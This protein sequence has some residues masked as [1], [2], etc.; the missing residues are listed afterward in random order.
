MSEEE[1]R[2]IEHLNSFLNIPTYVWIKESELLMVNVKIALNLIQKQQKVLEEYERIFD[3][4][5]ERK[6]RK[7]Y[8]EERR[9]E[10]PN[11]LY[12][13]TDEIY[14][15]YYEEKEKNNNLIKQLQEQNTEIQDISRQL[16]Q[17]KEKNKVLEAKRIWNKGRI[18]GLKKELEQEKEKNK[19]LEEKLKI[20]KQLYNDACVCITTECV[21][22]DKIKEKIEELEKEQKEYKN[23][24]EWEIQDDIVAQINIL[25]DLLEEK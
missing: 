25:K 2:A 4:F 6:Y 15:K 5:N 21:E 19:E 13:D 17:E 8:L 22:K 3:V 23:S 24:Q 12:P 18:E 10:E 16:R 11:L 20:A 9:K 7:K 1:K 14:Q